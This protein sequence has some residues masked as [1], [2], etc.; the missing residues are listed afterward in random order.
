MSNR[1]NT[2][3]PE[4]T[5]RLGSKEEDCNMTPLIEVQNQI[6]DKM[7]EMVDAINELKEQVKIMNENGQM[8]TEKTE[9]AITKSSSNVVKELGKIATI[10]TNTMSG[11]KNAAMGDLVRKET[12]NWQ[13]LLTERK[14][15]YWEFL[16]NLRIAATYSR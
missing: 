5:K 9:K 14:L 7:S 3:K 4:K 1:S 10:Q 12:P 13:N 16:R 11:L 6:L 8:N 15:D 2:E